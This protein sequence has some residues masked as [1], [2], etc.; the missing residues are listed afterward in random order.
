M[1]KPKLLLRALV[2]SKMFGK[3]AY[4]QFLRPSERLIDDVGIGCVQFLNEGLLAKDSSKARSSKQIIT[5]EKLI[6]DCKLA[7][8]SK[9]SE[10]KGYSTGNTYFIKLNDKPRL[11]EDLAQKFSNITLKGLEV[12][13]SH[14]CGAEWVDAGDRH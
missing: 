6:H 14:D 4:E 9:N 5:N 11:L 7:F 3:G 8:T 1:I 13:K 10:G 12:G 2:V